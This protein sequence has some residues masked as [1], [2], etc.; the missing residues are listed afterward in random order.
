M[1]ARRMNTKQ[2]LLLTLLVLSIVVIIIPPQV[3]HAQGSMGE[4]VW[5]AVNIT[6]HAGRL[7]DP[8]IRQQFTQY[9]AWGY[10]LDRVVRE[11]RYYIAYFKMWVPAGTRQIA[12]TRAVTVRA[13]SLAYTGL[14]YRWQ[15]LTDGTVC[16]YYTTGAIAFC[17]HSD[18]GI[19]VG[20]TEGRR[21]Y[22][23]R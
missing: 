14:S 13:S 9:F 12:T 19:S 22:G 15:W 20:A 11:G 7:S 10:T 5:K 17:T 18:G 4:F 23:T 6:T 3:V 21:V 2:C 8:E 16:A 1:G